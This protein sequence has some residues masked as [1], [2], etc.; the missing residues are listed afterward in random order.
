MKN[1]IFLFYEQNDQSFF[2]TSLRWDSSFK[3]DSRDISGE[4]FLQQNYNRNSTSHSLG[5]FPV[6]ISGN[7]FDRST[8]EE[9]DQEN[10]RA[11]FK[12]FYDLVQELTQ[13]FKIGVAAAEKIFWLPRRNTASIRPFRTPPPLLLGQL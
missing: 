13:D 2:E 8:S 12:D 1:I 7:R 3:I 4:S 11:K 10:Y 9:E 5:T 6:K